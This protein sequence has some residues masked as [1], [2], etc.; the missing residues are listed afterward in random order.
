M[1]RVLLRKTQR[2][3]HS[4]YKPANYVK[5]FNKPG[6]GVFSEE[7]F[8][9][10]LPPIKPPLFGLTRQRTIQLKCK[11]MTS[12]ASAPFKIFLVRP[13][14][15]L[16]ERFRRAVAADSTPI[17]GRRDQD[18]I[19]LGPVGV[20]KGP[21]RKSLLV[22]L[23]G[24][25]RVPTKGATPT[26]ARRCRIPARS[27]SYVAGASSVPAGGSSDSD[28]PGVERR[29]EEDDDV[30]EPLAPVPLRPELVPGGPTRSFLLRPGGGGGGPAESPR[31][32]RGGG[33]RRDGLP[34]SSGGLRRW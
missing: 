5:G 27:L 23:P 10:P 29:Q 4:S 9:T 12:G 19:I 20:P 34:P 8:S 1:L 26:A 3:Q 17:P 16:V 14:R 11:W 2:F 32:C 7:S 21:R 15:S 25:P 22:P 18:R 24:G 13:Q 28:P 6:G 31:R 30:V 33:G